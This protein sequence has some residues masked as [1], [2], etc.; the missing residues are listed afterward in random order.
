MA[1]KMYY[2]VHSLGGGELTGLGGRGSWD[3][4]GGGASPVHIS[5]YE[6]L[7]SFLSV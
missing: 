2:N 7:T 1:L 6:T 3:P 4:W 5:L